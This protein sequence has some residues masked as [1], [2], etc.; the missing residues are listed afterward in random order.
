[1]EQLVNENEIEKQNNSECININIIEHDD[2]KPNPIKYTKSIGEKLDETLN[3]INEFL[4]N[5]VIYFSDIN[6]VLNE[7]F[8][9][10]R[11]CIKSIYII[12]FKMS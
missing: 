5:T 9:P 7:L 12:K 1:M 6:M 4:Y 8:D 2:I 10:I 11:N 3:W